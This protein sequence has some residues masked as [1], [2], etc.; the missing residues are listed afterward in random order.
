MKKVFELFLQK[1]GLSRRLRDISSTGVYRTSHRCL[2]LILTSYYL[3]D[4]VTRLQWLLRTPFANYAKP[5][6]RLLAARRSLST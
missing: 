3:G 4:S 5:I 1:V 6:A 2:L